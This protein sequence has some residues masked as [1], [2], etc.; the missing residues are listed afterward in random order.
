MD[1]YLIVHYSLSREADHDREAVVT[2]AAVRRCGIRQ[3]MTLWTWPHANNCCRAHW[4]RGSKWTTGLEGSCGVVCFQNEVASGKSVQET[5]SLRSNQI[6]KYSRFLNHATRC[7]DGA[8]PII[9]TPPTLPLFN[10]RARLPAPLHLRSNQGPTRLFGTV[11]CRR[12]SL[13]RRSGPPCRSPTHILDL[14][15]TRDPAR[16]AS[17]LANPTPILSFAWMQALVLDH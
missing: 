14:S 7:P 12:P 13:P 8:R 10:L 17:K 11:W 3:A 2:C 4:G 6:L 16:Y 15:S 1:D 5:T 9:G